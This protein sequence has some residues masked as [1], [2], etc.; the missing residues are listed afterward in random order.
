MRDAFTYYLKDK[1]FWKLYFPSVFFFSI[2]FYIYLSISTKNTYI[3]NNFFEKYFSYQSLNDV[4]ILLLIIFIVAFAMIYVT[5]ITGFFITNIKEKI[6]SNVHSTP[7]FKFG[8]STIKG[9]LFG[10]STFIPEI[11][12]TLLY[13]IFVA[14]LGKLIQTFSNIPSATNIVIGI[15]LVI[16]A[17]CICVFMRAIAMVFVYMYAETN[18][19][20]VGLFLR[21][22][23]FLLRQN[24]KKYLKYNVVASILYLICNMVMSVPILFAKHIAKFALFFA[25]I[26][27]F[28][29][30]INAYLIAK[31]I[32]KQ[33]VDF[34]I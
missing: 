8:N 25:I 34:T 17:L 10:I 1:T 30:F 28:M 11:Y 16:L 18:N 9:I 4:F 20:F 26:Y 15:I 23:F 27:P 12:I 5:S 14:P 13:A 29:Y 31:S 32:K 21:R 22:A 6:T 33:A 3:L 2:C 7:E 24:F 19:I